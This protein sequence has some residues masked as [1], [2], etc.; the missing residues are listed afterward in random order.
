MKS[1]YT[2]FLTVLV[3]CF[4]V[5]CLVGCKDDSYAGLHVQDNAYIIYDIC[6][7]DVDFDMTIATDIAKRLATYDFKAIKNNDE[8]TGGSQRKVI[9]TDA[10]DLSFIIILQDNKFLGVCAQDGSQI[11]V[12][13]Y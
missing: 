13:S 2:K 3:S 5:F 7:T 1:L 12:R 4:M 10:N 6:K 8:Y 11:Y 9:L